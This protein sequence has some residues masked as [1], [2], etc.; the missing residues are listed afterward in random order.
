[1]DILGSAMNES[2]GGAARWY[3]RARASLEMVV[4]RRV[5]PLPPA[6]ALDTTP[7]GLLLQGLVSAA[8]GDTLGAIRR[9]AAVEALPDRERRRLGYGRAYLRA[10]LDARAGRW[11]AV[12]DSLGPAA[13]AGEHDPFSLDRVESMSMRW[14]VAHGWARLGRL[15]SATAVLE[16]VV[17]PTGMPPGHYCLRGF[18]YPFAL[19]QLAVW[20]LELGRAGQAREAWGRFASVF[21]A[22]DPALR[23][24]LVAPGGL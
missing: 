8:T 23:P 2:R 24:L 17:W 5:T 15:D 12:V 1:V 22:A 4:G 19:R 21:G 9:L 7:G 18:F 16:R 11:E 13:V 20:H 14:L 3:A 10:V 6:L